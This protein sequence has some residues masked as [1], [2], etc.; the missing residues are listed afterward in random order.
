M[1][2]LVTGGAGYIGSITNKLLR[3]KG[4]ETVIF[5]N[6]QT[7]HK[8]AASDTQFVQGDL[9][10]KTDID[11]VFK[12]V[13]IDAVVHFAA[14]ALAGESMQKPYDYYVNNIVGGLNLLEAMKDHGCQKIVFSSSCAVYGTPTKLPVAEDAPIHPESVYASSKRMFEEVL[15]WYETLYN[16]K[17]VILRYFNASGATL[18]GTLG[19]AHNPETHII[20]IALDVALGKRKEFEIYGDDYKTPDG[21]CI[22]DYIHV[23]DL[24]S[25]HILALDFLKNENKSDVFNLGVGRGYSNKVVLAMVEKIIGKELPKK[26]VARRSGDPDMIYAD[27]A[28]AKSEL[29][30]NPQYSDLETI[31]T[32]AWK[33]HQKKL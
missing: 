27:N 15:G 13:K 11:L 20:P 12:K 16:I 26:Y 28:K 29:G 6:L 9:K 2:I 32:S 17:S 7:G 4:F 21:T 33:W 5:D 31:V 14:L 8:T 22:R 18:E 24:A 25:A 3:D 19:E 1:A 10:N 23:L 30:W